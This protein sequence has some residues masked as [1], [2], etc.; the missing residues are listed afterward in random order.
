MVT[1]TDRGYEIE[2]GAAILRRENWM[3]ELLPLVEP[4][5]RPLFSFKGRYTA[6]RF[7]LG[8][9]VHHVTWDRLSDPQKDHWGRIMARKGA[10]S[11]KEIEGLSCDIASLTDMG[12]ELEGW[13]EE[14][15]A[16]AEI[17]E[18]VWR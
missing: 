15:R 2:V 6:L 16:V 8:H 7:G 14:Q 13:E 11:E 18:E 3:G 5:R 10:R 17:V 12:V 9:E 1:L 4:I